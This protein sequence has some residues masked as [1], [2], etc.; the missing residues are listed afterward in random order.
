[1]YSSEQCLAQTTLLSLLSSLFES[2]GEWGEG[3]L[4]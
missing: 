2:G 4:V 3:A 1:M